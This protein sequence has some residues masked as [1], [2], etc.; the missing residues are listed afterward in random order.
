MYQL[1]LNT[2]VKQSLEASIGDFEETSNE[3]KAKCSRGSINNATIGRRRFKSYDPGV[4][5]LEAQLV[6]NANQCICSFAKQ[7]QV[8]CLRKIS[9]QMLNTILACHH[10]QCS[11]LF[12]I[13]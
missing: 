8:F 1:S 5:T 11:E 10:I 7:D 9:L 2:P 12:L 13:T 3:K 6:S 4:A